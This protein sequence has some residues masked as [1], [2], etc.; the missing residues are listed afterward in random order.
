VGKL[1]QKVKLEEADRG[2]INKLRLSV[3]NL[4][5]A[6]EDRDLDL[7]KIKKDIALENLEE[8]EKKAK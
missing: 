7:L 8:V 4:G 5:S 3:D 6:M 1:E 2:L